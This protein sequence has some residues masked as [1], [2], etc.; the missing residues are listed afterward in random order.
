VRTSE[1]AR[2]FEAPGPF[3]SMYLA[4]E[5]DVE[6]AA[7][8]VALRWKNLRGELVDAGVPEGT[9]EAIDPLVEGSHKAGA[10]LAVIAAADGVVYAGNLPHPPPREWIVRQE[11]LPD[12]VPLLAWTQSLVPHVAVLTSRAH[13]DLAARVAE[14]P[15]RT[16]GLQ[17]EGDRSPH[18]SRT[19]PGGWSQPRYQHRSEVLWE[20]N[21]GEVAEVLARMV[22]RVRPR[23]VALAGDVRACELLREQSPKRVQELL[24]EVGG[25]LG[26]IDEVL[27][28]AEELARQTA[29]A[30]TGALLEEFEQERGQRDRAADGADATLEALARHQVRVLLLR[31]DPDD[32]R[33]AWF[34]EAPGQVAAR[35][36]TLLAEGVPVPVQGRLADVATRAA[37]GTGAEVRVLGPEADGRGPSGGV[38]AVLRYA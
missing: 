34:G 6:N 9:L 13:A 3:L 20:R 21:A 25:E 27:G 30:D 5:S 2:L 14:E 28:R 33:T 1:I 12:V 24:R 35:R 23:F 4:T 37:L 18:L 7:Q 15:E 10:T 17:V 36:E 16:Q 19:A 8:R 22:D 26:S 31:D 29:E 11:S 32:Q 38:G